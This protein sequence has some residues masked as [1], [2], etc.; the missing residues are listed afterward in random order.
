ME[1]SLGM[2]AGNPLRE[3]L[4]LL[5]QLQRIWAATPA[6]VQGRASARK[7]A[8]TGAVAEVVQGMAGILALREAGNSSPRVQSS[9]REYS[10]RGLG[11]VGPK[12]GAAAPVTQQVIAL[13]WKDCKRSP[14]TVWTGR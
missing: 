2:Y 8:P 7:D 1:S 5:D 10:E 13:R 14:S 9:I 11:M 4:D 6:N 12:E 3:Y